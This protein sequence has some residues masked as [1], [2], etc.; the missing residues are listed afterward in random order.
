MVGALLLE[1]PREFFVSV[2]G[3]VPPNTFPAPAGAA[4]W[5]DPQTKTFVT[6]GSEPD[7]FSDPA[8]AAKSQPNPEDEYWSRPHA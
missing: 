7:Q 4:E 5:A 2:P 1:A 6:G 8:P 3:F